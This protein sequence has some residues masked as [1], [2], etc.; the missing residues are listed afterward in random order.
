MTAIRIKNA[1]Y[2]R[3]FLANERAATASI[4]EDI[5]YKRMDRAYKEIINQMK[6]EN[7]VLGMTGD[8]KNECESCIEGKACKKSHRRLEGIRTKQIMELWDTDLIGPIK[9]ST[10]DNKNYILTVTDDFSRMV[11]VRLLNEKSEA[12]EEIERL[13]TI[14]ENQTQVK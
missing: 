1:Y 14:K 12:A 11:F 6:R 7:L 9:P 2:V 5:C 10:H 13:V 3:S 8:W 4:E